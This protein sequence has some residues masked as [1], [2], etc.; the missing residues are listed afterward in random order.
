VILLDENIPE[1]QRLLLL[2]SRVKPRQIGHD[3]STQGI[4]DER[5]IPLLHQESKTT[6]SLVIE[7]SMI[8]S[9]VTLDIVS[10]FWTSGRKMLPSLHGA[11]SEISGSRHG[12]QDRASSRACPASESP[13]G[14]CT[15]TRRASCP[16]RNEAAS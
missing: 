13:C 15:N 8:E 1:S 5:I 14:G 4:L 2:S 3:F 12:R 9:C 11:F 16:G 10:S 6:F 7:A